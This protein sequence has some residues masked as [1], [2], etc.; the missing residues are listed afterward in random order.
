MAAGLQIF[1]ATGGIT[2]DVA[3]R[4]AKILGSVYINAGESGSISPGVLATN[5]LYAMFYSNGG[6]YSDPIIVVSGGTISWA[7]PDYS[8]AYGSKYGSGTLVYGVF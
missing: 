6:G 7:C 5:Q 1:S 2:L 8:L 4:I 3:D